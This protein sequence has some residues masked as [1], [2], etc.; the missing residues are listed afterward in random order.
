[1]ITKRFYKNFDFCYII[2]LFYDY[3]NLIFIYKI[4]LYFKN[5][6]YIRYINFVIVIK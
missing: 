6:L 4:I 5:Q 2:A 1:M 3:I